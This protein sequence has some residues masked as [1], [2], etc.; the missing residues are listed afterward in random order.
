MVINL[1]NEKRLFDLREYSDL[2]QKDIAKEIGVTQQTYSLW[3]K[4]TKIIPLKHLNTLCNY[5]K[6]SMDY[7]LSLSDER[8]YKNMKYLTTLNKEEIGKRIKKIREDHGMSYNDLA[9]E[10]NTTKSTIYAYETGKTLILTA[11]AYQMCIK[12]KV[13]LDWLTGKIK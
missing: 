3:E 12:Y 7:V 1:M 2:Y 5:Y 8:T 11:F 6:V 4:G 13:S 10:L 9:K